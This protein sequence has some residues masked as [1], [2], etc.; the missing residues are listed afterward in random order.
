MKAILT[1]SAA[2]ELTIPTTMQ[3]RPQAPIMILEK[4]QSETQTLLE[5]CKPLLTWAQ[6]LMIL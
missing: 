3:F 5:T 2:R 1:L 4:A 6:V